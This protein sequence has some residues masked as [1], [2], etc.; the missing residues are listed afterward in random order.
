MSR[1]SIRCPT[2]GAAGMARVVR[3]VKTLRGRRPVIVKGVEVEECRRCGERLYDL[4]ALRKLAAARSR[5]PA[6]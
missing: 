6:A 4:T 5:R 1:T 3:D 2:C